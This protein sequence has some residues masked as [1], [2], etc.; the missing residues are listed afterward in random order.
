MISIIYANKLLCNRFF[1]VSIWERERVKKNMQPLQQWQNV[2]KLNTWHFFSTL[3]RCSFS[4]LFSFWMFFGLIS[5]LTFFPFFPLNENV[6]NFLFLVYNSIFFNFF[7]QL[8]F[9]KK[10]YNVN[11]ID[12]LLDIKDTNYWC[13]LLRIDLFHFFFISVNNNLPS[14][15]VYAKYQKRFLR[16]LCICNDNDAH[17]KRMT[18]FGSISNPNDIHTHAYGKDWLNRLQL[19]I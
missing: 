11:P 2:N 10:R 13:T 9:I 5:T 1:S 16:Y 19:W 6:N 3:N 14:H 8:F 7:K 12:C 18:A 17:N 4:F 15:R